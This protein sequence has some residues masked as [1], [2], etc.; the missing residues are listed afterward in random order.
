[1][2]IKQDIREDLKIKVKFK[3]SMALFPEKS[4]I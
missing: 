1:M 3:Q 2:P 4:W